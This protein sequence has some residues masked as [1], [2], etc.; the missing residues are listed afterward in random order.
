M[1]PSRGDAAGAPRGDLE[2]AA[3]P[4]PVAPAAARFGSAKSQTGVS[5]APSSCTSEEEGPATDPKRRVGEADAG[6]E[7]C[8]SGRADSTK[9]KHAE[10]D[11]KPVTPETARRREVIAR[12][13]AVAAA[14]ATVNL[15]AQKLFEKV[16]FNKV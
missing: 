15:K 8:F 2:I 4:A 6:G 12:A 11:S 5:T 10:S 3:A 13:M 9:T 16:G 7:P 14:A 1:P